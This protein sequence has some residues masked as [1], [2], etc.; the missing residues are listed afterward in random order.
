[1]AV[2]TSHSPPVEAELVREHR[3]QLDPADQQR[4]RDRQPGDRDVVEDLAH[5]LG[6]RPAVGEVHERAVERV[7]QRHAGREQDRQAQD[8]VERQPAA[9]AP[10]PASTSSATSVAVSNPSPNR[11]PERVH[12]P[13]LAHRARGAPVEAVHDARRSSSRLQLGLVE[14]AAAHP[15]EHPR[16]CRPASQVE[17]PDQQQERARHRAGR[18]PRSPG[19]APSRRPRRRRSARAR[20]ATTSTAEREHDRR[21]AEREEEP[22]G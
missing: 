8:R 2:T 15:P 4:D 19:G 1:M 7:E 20:R 22:D 6:E 12:V 14:V 9:A 11:Q 18:S 16:R 17:Q 13:R 3:E 5:R 21:V 10:A